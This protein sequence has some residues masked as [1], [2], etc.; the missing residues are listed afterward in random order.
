MGFEFEF[1]FGSATDFALAFG[2]ES[3][4]ERGFESGFAEGGD[5]IALGSELDF[6]SGHG[7][8]LEFVVFATKGG[9]VRCCSGT[10]R[11]RV[12]G[13]ARRLWERWPW[14]RRWRQRRVEKEFVEDD[15]KL[16]IGLHGHGRRE[17]RYVGC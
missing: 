14:T 17:E 7:S 1:E 3:G 5:G 2:V 13:R 8:A 6:G 11:W 12:G 4:L 10:W 16:E 9:W 15:V